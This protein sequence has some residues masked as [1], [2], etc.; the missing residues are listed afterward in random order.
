MREIFTYG[1]VGRAP[2]NRCL[3]PEEGPGKAAT[4]LISFIL[5]NFWA[6]KQALAIRFPAP[7]FRR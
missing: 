6:L 4:F 7:Q 5:R 3:Y 1:S 2:G